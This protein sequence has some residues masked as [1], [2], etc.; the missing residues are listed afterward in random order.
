[1][2]ESARWRSRS[3]QLRWLSHRCNWRVFYYFGRCRNI[4]IATL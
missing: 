1:M 2:V 4:D 3:M